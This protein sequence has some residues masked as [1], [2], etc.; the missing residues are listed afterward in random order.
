MLQV[1]HFAQLFKEKHKKD[2]TDRYNPE[3]VRALQRLR[4]NCERAKR[5]L[6]S[7]ESTDIEIEEFFEGID[8]SESIT[9]AKFEELNQDLFDSCISLV[10]NVLQ[11]YLKL[12]IAPRFYCQE[13]WPVGC[14]DLPR[15]CERP[16]PRGRIDA[17]TQGSGDALG[18]LWR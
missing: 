16:G 8:F 17:H 14:W 4:R 13:T 11:V 15:G 2:L 6:S 7:A 12:P 1:D 10:G 18:L 5:T 9:R 3:A